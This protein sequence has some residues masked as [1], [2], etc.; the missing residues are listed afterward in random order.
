VEEILQAHRNAAF[1]HFGK[2]Q[3]R[4]SNGCD[5]MKVNL[6]KVNKKINRF[7]WF[8]TVGEDILLSSGSEFAV[9]TGQLLIFSNINFCG[10]IK[11]L[12]LQILWAVKYV[13]PIGYYP[14]SG[15]TCSLLLHI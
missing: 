13:R 8:W 11:I 6:K 15:G 14:C 4:Y 10:V 3:H 12:E 7:H 2:R 1:K 5:N 9:S